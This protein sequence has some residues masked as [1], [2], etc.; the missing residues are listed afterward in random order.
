MSNY[1]LQNAET[2]KYVRAGK[3]HSTD[4]TTY[5]TSEQAQRALG[6]Y[7]RIRGSEF[8]AVDVVC[9]FDE[10]TVNAYHANVDRYKLST[11]TGQ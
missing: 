6:R 10:D 8:D 11:R 3:W 9:V 2:K 7:Q 4:M 1:A 5:V